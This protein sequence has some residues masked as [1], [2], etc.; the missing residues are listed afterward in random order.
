MSIHS[1]PP[2]I[3]QAGAALVT[4]LIFM[5]ILTIIVIAALR[6]ATL[7]ERM[8]ANAL[9]RQ[10]AL[11]AA[12]AALREAEGRIL[13]NTAAGI[14]PAAPFD[15]FDPTQFVAAC[16]DGLCNL[17][18]DGLRWKNV[19]WDEAGETATSEIEGVSQPP[20]YIIELANVPVGLVGG[21]CPKILYRIT[22]QGFGRDN[23]QVLVQTMVRSLPASCPTLS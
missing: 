2:F 22:A 21:I 19:D 23:S 9:N 1:R 15:P 5:V 13:G 7:E 10:I 12:E 20:R 16:T 17:Q 6:S 3:H 18:A 14:A 11:Q 8:A 4:G